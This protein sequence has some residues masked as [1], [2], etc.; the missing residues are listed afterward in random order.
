MHRREA[1]TKAL[2][3]IWNDISAR[4]LHDIPI[5]CKMHCFPP[6]IRMRSTFPHCSVSEVPLQGQCRVGR[7]SRVIANLL[8]Y[9]HTPSYNG[10]TSPATEGVGPYRHYLSH[11]ITFSSSLL[12][13]SLPI[14][15]CF[16]GTHLIKVLRPFHIPSQAWNDRM[17]PKSRQH[18]PHASQ[19]IT[20]FPLRHPTRLG[21]SPRNYRCI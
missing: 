6:F 1:P 19:P 5:V 20:S 16:N 8:S 12:T 3:M 11:L 21:N 4:I 15:S 2:L 7:T 9:K 10:I 13:A 14:P 17:A 18:Q